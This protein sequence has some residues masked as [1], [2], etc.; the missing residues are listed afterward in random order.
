MKLKIEIGNFVLS[1][2]FAFFLWLIL[3]II[4]GVFKNFYLSCYRIGKTRTVESF[5]NGLIVFFVFLVFFLALGFLFKGGM[6][7]LPLIVLLMVFSLGGSVIGIALLGGLGNIVD[8]EKQPQAALGT[9]IAVLFV[10]NIILPQVASFI[11]TAIGIYGIG[12]MLLYFRGIRPEIYEGPLIKSERKKEPSGGSITTGQQQRAELS[13]EAPLMKNLGYL[14]LAV[15]L[16]IF[17]FYGIRIYNKMFL[18]S[19]HSPRTESEKISSKKEQAKF[20]E[21]LQESLSKTRTAKEFA[22]PPKTQIPPKKRTITD[23]EA[24]MWA[25]RIKNGEFSYEELK[26]YSERWIVSKDYKKRL[27]QKIKEYLDVE[28]LQNISRREM[29]RLNKYRR[30]N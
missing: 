25:F 18:K 7:P 22:A 6:S 5:T 1:G 19:H 3:S 27:F 13:V 15:G 10:L 16:L 24:Q 28:N 17:S 29:E 21:K 2:M 4:A 26:G 11:N 9:G 14:M 8:G 23:I 12:T 30:K 20:R